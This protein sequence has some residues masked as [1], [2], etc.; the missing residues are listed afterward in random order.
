MFRLERPAI[1]VEDLGVI[2]LCPE[3]WQELIDIGTMSIDFESVKLKSQQR[4]VSDHSYAGYAPLH[5]DEGQII[6][7]KIWL[8]TKPHSRTLLFSVSH[9]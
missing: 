3:K 4:T 8:E 2:R 5:F 9:R 6:P 7:P 1:T